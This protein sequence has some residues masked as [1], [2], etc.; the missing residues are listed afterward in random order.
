V[1]ATG[2]AWLRD[3]APPLRFFVR[4]RTGTTVVDGK[5]SQN[6]IENRS[7]FE[8]RA[9]PEVI[10]VARLTAEAKN[11]PNANYI[12]ERIQFL[13]GMNNRKNKNE[14]P[15]VQKTGGEVPERLTSGAGMKKS[16]IKSQILK[17]RPLSIVAGR[18]RGDALESRN[19]LKIR[20]A[21][22]AFLI[23]S[24]RR[25]IVACFG[26]I[27]LQGF[28]PFG[29]H[30]DAPLLHSLCGSTIIQSGALL[31]LFAREV[32]RRPYDKRRRGRKDDSERSAN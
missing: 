20:W 23:E 14:S 4:R 31:G 15:V 32:W 13:E 9:E 18:R 17:P 24:L 10:D 29:F 5:C 19:R 6:Q 12:T 26:L 8:S 2:F 22:C 27:L 11:F 25:S 21:I 1:E 16:L 7:W 30:M 3:D 28:H